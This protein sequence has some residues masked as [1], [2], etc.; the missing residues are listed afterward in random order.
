[1][2]TPSVAEIIRTS[3]DP[4][5]TQL[6]FFAEALQIGPKPELDLDNITPPVEPP[7]PPPPPLRT[8]EV[9]G[10]ALGSFFGLSYAQSKTPDYET[11][12]VM[13]L[14]TA[15]SSKTELEASEDSAVPSE[16]IAAP[17]EIS[18]AG[19]PVPPIGESLADTTPPPADWAQ[20]ISTGLSESA[21]EERTK[22]MMQAIERLDQQ[23]SGDKDTADPSPAA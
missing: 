11:G 5:N 18:S 19:E 21:L 10:N 17:P 15:D 16:V 23:A 4:Y 8:P 22:K 6:G 12:P 2:E 13:P 3:S 20:G 7:P 9:F 1:M 14:V